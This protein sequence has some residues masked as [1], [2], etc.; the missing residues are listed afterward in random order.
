[1]R[2]QTIRLIVMFALLILT[3]PLVAHAQSLAKVPQ[4]GG[5]LFSGPDSTAVET[6]RHG[7]RVHGWVEGQNL[8]IAWRFAARHAERLPALAADLVWSS[9]FHTT[10]LL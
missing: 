1:V 2:L 6:L 3:A 10:R 7:L 4:T 9:S 8:T 5:L